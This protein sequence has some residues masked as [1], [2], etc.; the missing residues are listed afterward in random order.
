MNYDQCSKHLNTEIG[1]NIDSREL[2]R[3]TAIRFEAM[4]ERENSCT[5]ALLSA[6]AGTPARL[7]WNTRENGESVEC[8]QEPGRS[9]GRELKMKV[10]SMLPLDGEL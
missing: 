10:L 2:A 6:A 8:V 1:L 9:A 4:T 5:L 7:V 3:Q